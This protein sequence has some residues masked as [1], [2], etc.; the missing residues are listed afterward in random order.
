MIFDL[1]I[2][3]NKSPFPIFYKGGGGGASAAAAAQPVPQAIRP[4]T[5]RI[6]D[7]NTA[8]RD[9]KKKQAKRKG[10]GSTILAGGAGG[11]QVQ[12][13][14]VNSNFGAKTLLGS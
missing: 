11:G 3:A 13:G 1:P 2:R 5:E 9:F 12:G 7:L 10:I 4:V 8:E 14:N 6:S